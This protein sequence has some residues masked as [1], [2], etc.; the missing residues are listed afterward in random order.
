MATNQ[1]EY[2]KLEQRSVKIFLL[3]EKYKPC[4]IYLRIC[5]VYREACFSQKMFTN[6]LNMVYEPDSKR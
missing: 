4:E 1:A 5:D 3:A 6:G 2:S